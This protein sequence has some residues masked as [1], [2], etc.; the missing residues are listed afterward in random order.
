MWP[1]LWLDCKDTEV[2]DRN[3]FVTTPNNQICA[4]CGSRLGEVWRQ[5]QGPTSP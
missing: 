2:L 3:R 1:A 5:E 4:T